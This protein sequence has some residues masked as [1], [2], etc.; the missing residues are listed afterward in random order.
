MPPGC[1]KEIKLPAKFPRVLWEH[2]ELYKRRP[3]S[4]RAATKAATQVSRL[5]AAKA[6]ERLAVARKA[7]AQAKVVAAA[8][9]V[10][11]DREEAIQLVLKAAAAI[12]E[13]LM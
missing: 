1:R 5:V 4:T 10:E 6:A 3:T 13:H 7:K 11:A 9:K 12:Q 8:A 2:L